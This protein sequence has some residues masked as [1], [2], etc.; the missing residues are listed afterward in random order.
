MGSNP[1]PSATFPTIDTSVGMK[2]LPEDA[3]E[4]WSPQDLAS[5][6]GHDDPSWYVVGGWAL[7]LWHGRLTREHEDLE[8]AV[9]PGQVGRC[10]D[11]LSDLEFFAARDGNLTHHPAKTALATDL[12]QLWG[13]DMTAGFWR[14]DMM[15]ER[16]TPDF[17]IYKREPAIRVPRTAAIR[18]NSTGIAYLAPAIVLLFKAK[19]RR[20]K[21]DLDFRTALPRL[22][23]GERADLTGWLEAMHPGHGWIASLREDRAASV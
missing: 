16:G 3:W 18:R 20:E 10:R 15:I 11:L 14:V 6:L 12:W 22:D 17:W 4:P 23:D 7:D 13:A 5:R 1:T 19:H 8:F 2:P 9:L 21:D